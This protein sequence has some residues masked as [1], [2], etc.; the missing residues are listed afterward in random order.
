MV[1][2]VKRTTVYLD[3][4]D[5]YLLR[6]SCGITNVSSFIQEL[7]ESYI[8]DATGD[9]VKAIKQEHVLTFTQDLKKKKLEQ[10]KLIQEQEE[11]EST[12][13]QKLREQI[14]AF[15]SEANHFFKDQNG[16][17]QKLPDLD[18]QYDQIPKWEK[19]AHILTNTCGFPVSVEECQAFVKSRGFE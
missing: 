14:E 1:F 19:A 17:Y 10:R 15:A 5:V 12:R 7:I 9:K 3:E 13:S 2:P 6:H 16:W 11:T 18:P 8:F 4:D